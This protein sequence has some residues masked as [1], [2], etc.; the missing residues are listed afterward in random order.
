MSWLLSRRNKHHRKRLYCFCYAGGNASSF[1]PWQAGLSPEI[2]VCAVQLPGR[3]MR[4]SE[5]P[6]SSWKTL[7][8]TLAKVINEQ[9]DLPFAFFGHSLGGLVA[10]ELARYCAQHNHAMPAKLIVSG[11]AAPQRRDTS[12][13]LHELPDEK[14]IQELENYNGTPPEVL[15]HQELMQLLLPAIRSDFALGENY[16]Y[17]SSP[18]LTIPLTVF[19]GT[20]DPY[21][22][23]RS[24]EG[25]AQETVGS[26]QICWF[27]GDHF[28]INSERSTI[29]NCLNDELLSVEEKVA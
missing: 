13:R 10:F 27:N 26:F 22:S 18:P 6:C 17:T 19:A 4:I 29:L 2:E 15:E 21:V 14:L 20:N 3:G 12:Q 23:E 1:L 11:C 7:I 25:W 16:N 9:N 5:P 28:F 8:E 24:A